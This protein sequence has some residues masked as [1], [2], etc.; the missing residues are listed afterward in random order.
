MSS[1]DLR[2]PRASVDPEKLKIILKELKRLEAQEK[3]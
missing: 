1:H 3:K 2:M